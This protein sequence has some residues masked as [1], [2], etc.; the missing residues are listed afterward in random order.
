MINRKS[1]VKIHFWKF[2]NWYEYITYITIYINYIT[3]V[4]ID[5]TTKRLRAQGVK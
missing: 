4:L 2:G 5:L 1:L 3:N